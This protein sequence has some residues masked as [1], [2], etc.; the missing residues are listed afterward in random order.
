[1][2]PVDGVMGQSCDRPIRASRKTLLVAPSTRSIRYLCESPSQHAVMRHLDLA[3][4][5]SL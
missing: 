1:M 3:T 2:I 4:T 5:N